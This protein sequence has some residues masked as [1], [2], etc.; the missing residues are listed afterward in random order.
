MNV[1]EKIKQFSNYYYN[2]G[3]K[4]AQVRDL[5][6]AIEMLEKSL[7]FNKANVEARNL[8]GLVYYETGEIV[9]ALREWVL[10]ANYK[11]EDNKAI[12]YIQEIQGDVH[13]LTSTNQTVRYYNNALESAK[14]GQ[15]D[16]SIIQLKKAVKLCPKFIRAYQLLA[17]LYMHQGTYMKAKEILRTAGRIDRNNT[18]TLR[19]QKQVNDTLRM[20]VNTHKKTD[21]AD[22][23]L[24][25]VVQH[26]TY[27]AQSNLLD[28]QLWRASLNI[29][30]GLIVGVL[31]A[32]FL[33]LPS[34]E[35]KASALVKN[36][37]QEANTTI[38][39]KNV[40][41]NDL[42]E[43]VE[44]LTRQLGTM[45]EEQTSTSSEIALYQ[46]MLMAY[47]KYVDGDYV[48]AGTLIDSVDET[49][50]SEDMQGTYDTVKAKI[51]EEYMKSLLKTAGDYYNQSK[52]DDAISTYQR[53]MAIDENYMDGEAMYYAAQS[54][55]KNGDNQKAI[56]LYQKVIDNYP[57]TQKAYNAQS[58]LD[59][60]K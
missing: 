32:Y 20:D 1:I 55:R 38:S 7:Q 12:G 35:D 60:M 29:I 21:K 15:L 9:L 34:Q 33:I 11:K 59:G 44:G 50:V 16:M 49:A 3:L 47:V 14:H 45:N 24:G 5:S 57:E 56:V 52:F 43:Q 25:T 36:Q 17:L 54:Y 46:K 2:I 37:L 23:S 19:Y 30:I 10:S 4:R 28:H 31:I 48:G 51:N 27:V 22:R 13:L 18:T 39:S 6:G 8:L 53:I 41:I 42:T 26:E 58:Y 40:K